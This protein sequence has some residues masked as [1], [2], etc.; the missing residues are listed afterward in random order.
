M[1]WIACERRATA[2]F[3]VET[4]RALF[5]TSA[6]AASMF[7]LFLALSGLV[8]RRSDCISLA[9]KFHEQPQA[10]GL[11]LYLTGGGM[12]LAPIDKCS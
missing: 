5:L 11:V 2:E 6:L 3:D 12:Q 7:A 1:A 9:R 4:V 8:A 10:P